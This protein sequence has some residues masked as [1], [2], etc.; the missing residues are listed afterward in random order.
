M[1]GL[2]CAWLLS[3]AACGRIDFGALRDASGTPG[4]LATDGD[5]GSAFATSHFIKASNT[6]AGDLF[7]YAVAVSGD[8][9]TLAISARFESSAAT[10]IDGN[11][12]DTSA[13][14]A[15]A[16]YVFVRAGTTWQQQAYVK[17][18]NTNAADYFG[19][20]LAL[21]TTGDT[22]VVGAT[23]EASAA[24]GVDGNQ[25]DNS[26]PGAG[27][28]YV[29]VRAGT[30]W[31]QQAYLKASNPG[32]NYNFGATT[33]ISGDGST[34]AICAT[35]EASASAGIDG[36]QA[37]TS[38]PSAGAVYVFVAGA[39]T[40]S[41]QA[42]VK[43]SNPDAGD[44]FGEGIGL[45]NDG[46]T[47]AI[48]AYQE[49]SG[50]T[51]VNGNQAD[52]S[53]PQTGALYVFAR[54]TMWSQQAYVKATPA[55]PRILG[56]SLALSSDASTLVAGA[57]YDS[58]G[59]T[60]IGADPT[61]GSATESGAVLVFD[62]AAPYAQ[63]SFVKAPTASAN[64]QMGWSVAV[65]ADGDVIVAGIQSYAGTGAAVVTTNLAAERLFMPTT[66]ASDDQLGWSV[67]VSGDG[68]TIALGTPG[69]NSSATGIDGDATDTSATRS[70]AVYVYQ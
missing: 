25:L 24:S 63:R 2:V 20:S 33:A 22:L 41:Q 40:W 32:G 59:A 47:L 62:G 9:S 12:S 34:I 58:S 16:V 7:G 60:G 14:D 51:G 50:A 13:T 55:A 36:N 56:W 31:S 57:P 49:A 64:D 11:Q 15:G 4:D 18:S 38:E 23:N 3:L 53:A 6:H 69:N 68:R 17:A 1:R 19:T 54:A 28:A 52:N 66:L 70:G 67:A 21:S 10:G 42:Y 46:N 44:F 27:A 8:G 30:T 65:S 5:T 48:G 26:L 61:A 43:A 37:D 45:S 35:N 39:G 29:F